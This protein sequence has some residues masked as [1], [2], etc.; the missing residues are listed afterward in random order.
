[1]SR[2]PSSKTANRPHGPPPTMRA[3]V[4]ITSSVIL[5]SG[6]SKLLFGHVHAQAVKGIGYLD[7]AGQ[8]AGFAHVEGKIEHILFH[9]PPGPGLGHP[10]RIDIDVAGRTGTSTPAIGIDAGHHVF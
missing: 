6:L 1:M 5:H 9:L 10:A 8:P 7:L 2:R 3:S 4:E